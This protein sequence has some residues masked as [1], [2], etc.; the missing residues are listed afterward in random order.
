MTEMGLHIWGSLENFQ[1]WKKVFMQIPFQVVF[2]KQDGKSRGWPTVLHYMK[3][4][5]QLNAKDLEVYVAV[6]SD[7]VAE[8]R[9]S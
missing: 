4:W 7:I 2:V 9:Q 5:V 6:V 3:V 8:Q 1:S